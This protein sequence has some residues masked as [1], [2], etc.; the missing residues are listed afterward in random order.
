VLAL[1]ENRSASVPL[2]G[3]GPSATTEPESATY[4]VGDAASW[5]SGSVIVT[6]L[7]TAK[8]T[9]SPGWPVVSLS[10]TAA[11]ELAVMVAASS[12]PLMVTSIERVTAP[13]SPDWA[14]K[15]IVW[16]TCWSSSSQLKSPRL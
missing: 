7:A 12:W 5:L 16:V 14:W 13:S 4:L 2:G 8:E 10:N 6:V 15:L 9:A 3:F 11:G 1:K